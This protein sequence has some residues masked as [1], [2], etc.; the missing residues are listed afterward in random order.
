MGTRHEDQP[1]EH[2]A[3]AASLDPTPVWKQYLLIGLGVLGALVLVVAYFALGVIAGAM[4][5]SGNKSSSTTAPTTPPLS[6]PTTGAQPASA[7]PAP[8]APAPAGKQW[9]VIKQFAGDGIKDTEQ[10][11]VG[12]EWR[13][14]WDYTPPQY[15]GIIQIYVYDSKNSFFKRTILPRSVFG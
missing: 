5:S 7:A 12:S 6:A 9:V 1:P 13:I 11:T 3:G 8:A 4:A 14:D 2:W 10:F 15:G